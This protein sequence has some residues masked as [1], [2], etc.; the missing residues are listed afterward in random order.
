MHMDKKLSYSENPGRRSYREAER[1]RGREKEF[2]TIRECGFARRSLGGSN[3]ESD[4][5]RY[6]NGDYANWVWISTATSLAAGKASFA[7]SKIVSSVTTRYFHFI[8]P[9]A[10]LNCND[11]SESA[12]SSRRD[13]DTATAR[14]LNRRSFLDRE[15]FPVREPVQLEERIRFT[16]PAKECPRR[17]AWSVWRIR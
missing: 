11:T 12:M 7:T 1:L 4:G 8:R 17:R 16:F 15:R 2:E 3:S 6:A 10:G 9:A 13:I 5:K 14:D